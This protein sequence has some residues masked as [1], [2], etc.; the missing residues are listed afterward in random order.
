MERI[1]QGDSY[2]IP[3]LIKNRGTVITPETADTVEITIGNIIKKY[4]GEIY[5]AEHWHLPLSQQD[6]FSLSPGIKAMQARVRFPGGDVIGA[7]C[8]LISISASGSKE[9]L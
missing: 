2:D 9:E 1:M 7:D 6:T 4:P 3:V 8:G 5:F